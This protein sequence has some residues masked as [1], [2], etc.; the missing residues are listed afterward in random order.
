MKKMSSLWKIF[1]KKGFAILTILMMLGQIGQG[2][3]TAFANELAVGD[4]GALDVTLL[5]GDKQD[6]PDGMSIIQVTLCLVTSRSP[7]RI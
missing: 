2:A 1:L 4:N 5:Y 3:M 7:L 6:H